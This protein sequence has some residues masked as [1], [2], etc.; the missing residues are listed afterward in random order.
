MTKATENCAFHEN[1]TLK[2]H[3]QQC[4]SINV[5]QI[6]FIFFIYQTWKFKLYAREIF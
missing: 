5:E 2:L 3:H 6:G 1:M 4:H